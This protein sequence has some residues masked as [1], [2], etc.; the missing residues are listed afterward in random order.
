MPSATEVKY[1][2]ELKI[3]TVGNAT[4]IYEIDHL[5]GKVFKDYVS[6][7]KFMLAAK[8]AKK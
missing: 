5:D 7:L 8:K 2:A 4:A 1:L 6:D 3:R